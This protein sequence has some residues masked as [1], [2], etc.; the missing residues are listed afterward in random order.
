MSEFYEMLW[1]V[2]VGEFLTLRAI[3][4][5]L[6]FLNFYQAYKHKS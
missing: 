5:S 2:A 3:V 4:N 1:W 6:I